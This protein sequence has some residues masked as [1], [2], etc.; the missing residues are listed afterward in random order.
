MALN[1][2]VN[3]ALVA[4]AA[5]EEADILAER[6][7]NSANAAKR[8]TVSMRQLQ[9]ALQSA[10]RLGPLKTALAASTDEALKID[11]EKAVQV[12]RGDSMVEGARLL[13]GVG[14][15]AIDAIFVQAAS[16]PA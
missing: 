14:D 11:W 15:A 16:L 6:A 8:V 4:C 1:R 10:G 5:Q 7:A 9:R 2:W 13:M 12:S 3:G